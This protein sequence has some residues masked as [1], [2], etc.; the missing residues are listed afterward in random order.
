DVLPQFQYHAV[1]QVDAVQAAGRDPV[2]CKLPLEQR[3]ALGVLHVIPGTHL[4]VAGKRKRHCHDDRHERDSRSHG[5]SPRVFRR[6]G[7]PV[8]AAFAAASAWTSATCSPLPP[9]AQ[10]PPSNSLMRTQVTPR[11]ASPSTAT[12]ASVTLVMS[13][14]FCSGVKTS[15]MTSMVT[16][17]IAKLLSGGDGPAPGPPDVAMEVWPPRSGHAWSFAGDLLEIRRTSG[18]C[19]LI[20]KHEL[21]VRPVRAGPCEA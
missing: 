7:W 14:R 8:Q 19:C 17:G 3:R 10:S 6:N 13:S 21:Q 2:G 20:L 16:M 1:V 18:A 5:H 12:T 11:S 9:M 15:L 4:G